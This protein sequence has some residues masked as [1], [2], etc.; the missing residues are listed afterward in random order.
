MV[1]VLIID[2]NAEFAR[3]LELML[4]DSFSILKA[5]T[6]V[7]GLEMLRN[8]QVSIVLLDLQLPDIPGLEVLE[9]I[10]SEIDPYLPVI[11][12]TEYDD[13]QYVVKAMRLGA[14]DFLSKDVHVELM[15]EKMHQ[16]LRQKDLKLK[17]SGIQDESIMAKDAFIYASD[18]MK[19]IS[20]EITKLANLDFDVLLTGETGVGKDMI[21]SQIHMRGKRKDKPFL[22]VP[23]RSLSETV[24]ESEL[25]GHEK[26][27]FTGADRL[28]IGKFESSNHGIVYLPEISNLPENIQLKLLH[29]MQYKKIARIG[30][31]SRK[32]DISLDVRLISA[33]NE[34]LED[35]LKSGR[36][37]EDF[38]YRLTGITL[39]IPPLR[40][41]VADIVPLANYFLG[42]FSSHFGKSV[43][44]FSDEA[45]EGFVSYEWR[46]NVR[47]LSN[48]IK[49]ALSY[50]DGSVLELKHF[51]NILRFKSGSGMPGLS[52]EK[53][54]DFLQ[55]RDFENKYKTL[56][57]KSLMERCN[58][59]VST[60]A[61]L[62]GLTPQGFRKILK[63]LNLDY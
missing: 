14:Y 12:I 1:N 52:A 50:T 54:G 56:Y 26:G 55:Y 27:S 58:G 43:Y 45:L 44:K 8:H 9:I 17:V 7:K 36:I 22:P 59:K 60:A 62:A 38:Y 13:A 49:N 2:D 41:R 33:T 51:P 10:H 28:K 61:D 47:E 34:N 35:I 29:F 15:K 23:I 39:H 18:A 37:R 31:D 3:D 20:Y 30:Q 11:I 63:Q 5:E 42:K 25:F 21:A 32:G 4:K 19:K 46:G 40:E 24:L 16:S 53:D 6:S 48:S 57:F